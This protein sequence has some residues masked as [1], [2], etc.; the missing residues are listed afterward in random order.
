M[1]RLRLSGE[2]VL[3][4]AKRLKPKNFQADLLR[5][6]FLLKNRHFASRFAVTNLLFAHADIFT[7]ASA[8]GAEKREEQ[9]LAKHISIAFSKNTRKG[10]LAFCQL[11]SHG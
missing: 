1:D 10:G 11:L 7:G 8:F 2:N 4:Y 9:G 3:T 5:K 6:L